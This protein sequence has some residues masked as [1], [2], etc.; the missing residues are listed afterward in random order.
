[1]SIAASFPVTTAAIKRFK[2]AW[3]DS[4]PFWRDEWKVFRAY[5]REHAVL[6]QINI[7]V[8]IMTVTLATMSGHLLLASILVLSHISVAA[9]MWVYALWRTEGEARRNLESLRKIQATQERASI[10]DEALQ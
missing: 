2:A 4:K 5:A 8:I 3:A 6:L 10:P 7:S 9:F 1:M